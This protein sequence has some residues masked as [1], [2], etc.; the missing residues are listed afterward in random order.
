MSFQDD[1]KLKLGHLLMTHSST[2]KEDLVINM[3]VKFCSL[4]EVNMVT[5][6]DCRC[7]LMHFGGTKIHNKSLA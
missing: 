3:L 5:H 6:S 2:V 7:D 4:F 1:V